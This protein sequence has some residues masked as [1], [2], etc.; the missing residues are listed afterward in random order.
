MKIKFNKK[1]F[2]KAI[3]I[4]GCFSSKRT[5]LPILCCIKVSITEDSCWILSYDDRNAIKTNFRLEN[6]YDSIDFCIE[7]DDIENYVSLLSEDVFELEID[8]EKL[9]AIASTP[10]STMTFPLFNVDEFP[11]LAVETQSDT[12]ELDAEL[13]GY[14]LKKASSFLDTDEFQLNHEHLHLFIKDKKIDVFAFNF[15]KMYHDSSF[16]N[17]EGELKMSINRSA[18]FGL[19]S[20]LSKE[21][22][23]TIKNGEK[24]ILVIGE[25]TMLLIRKYDFT[26]HDYYMLLQYKPLFEVEV[27]KE[28]MISI[29]ARA[30]NVHDNEK[31]G[32]LTIFFNENGLTFVS[33]KPEVKKRLEETIQVSGAKEFKQ[34]YILSKLMLAL[35]AI[36]S[37]QIVLR[38]CGTN[39][40][41]EIGNTEYTTES[42]YV[43]PCRD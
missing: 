32:S 37:D 3:R 1:D 40:L 31:M 13:F 39:A 42:S 18:F 33:E 28:R 7:K 20:A 41:F 8:N 14:W 26:P 29:V 5:T 23:V 15:D 16:I 35:N 43:S 22:K 10:Y 21:K 30:M 11:A 6:R 34:T 25:D 27:S 24:N 36:S 9:S 17:F 12:F 38:P 2:L 4:G 19:R